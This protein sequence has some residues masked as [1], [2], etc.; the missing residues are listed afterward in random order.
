MDYYSNV[1]IS[2]Y[3]GDDG[4]CVCNWMI[5]VV[6]VAI[7]WLAICC[8]CTHDIHRWLHT[9]YITRCIVQEFTL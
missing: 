3:G 6:I 1:V 2:Y 9:E 5:I 8:H 4:R 7:S